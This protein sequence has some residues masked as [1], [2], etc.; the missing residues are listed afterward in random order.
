VLIHAG[1][2]TLERGQVVWQSEGD[3]FDGRWTRPLDSGASSANSPLKQE[4]WTA[5]LGS[6]S[7][8]KPAL[9]VQ[10]LAAFMPGRWPLGELR[11]R[12]T[13]PPTPR[14]WGADLYQLGII[15]RN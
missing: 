6:P 3:A 4:E 2:S 5:V 7:F 8:R 1:G 15:T 11:T 13:F 9:D 10:F 14:K 12:P